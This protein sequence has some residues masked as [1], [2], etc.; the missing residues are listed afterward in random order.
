MVTS[1]ARHGFTLAQAIAV[2]EE[3]GLDFSS[4]AFGPEKSDRSH[5][6]L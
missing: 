5:V 1:V 2:A 6:V 4:E 3:I